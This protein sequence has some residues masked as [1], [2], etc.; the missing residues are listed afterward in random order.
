[1]LMSEETKQKLN[2]L[3][4]KFFGY[5]SKADNF[6]YNLAFYSYPNISEIYHKSFAHY[7]TGDEMADMISDFM[8][9]LDAKAQ[10]EVVEANTEDY[11]GDIAKIFEDNLQMCEDC[12]TSIMEVIDTADFNNDYEVKIKF[13]ELLI[14]F[15]PYRKQAQVWATFAKRYENDWKT[16]DIYFKDL[17]KYIK[18]VS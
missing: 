13:E 9:L 14:S 6:A 2:Q 8:D 4:G 11:N 17:T 16:F 1:M 10:R 12:R 18:V 3:L 15:M 7:F 5:N